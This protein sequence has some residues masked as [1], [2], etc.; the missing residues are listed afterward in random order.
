MV[1]DAVF[2]VMSSVGKVEAIYHEGDK[3]RRHAEAIGGYV[4]PEY[5]LEDVPQFVKDFE[6]G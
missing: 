2:L 3:A 4:N 5:V 1:V 6:K